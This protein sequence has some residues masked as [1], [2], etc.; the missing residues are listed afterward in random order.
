M[1]YSRRAEAKNRGGGGLIGVC[2]GFSGG[3]V[4]GDFQVG[5]VKGQGSGSSQ[6]RF[7]SLPLCIKR[8]S[9]SMPRRNTLTFPVSASANCCDAG[10]QATWAAPAG[11]LGRSCGHGRFRPG[12]VGQGQERRHRKHQPV[13]GDAGGVGPSGL[14]PLPAHALDGLEAQ[15]DPEAESVPTHSHCFRRQVGEDDPGFL[16]AGRTRPPAG[17]S[18]VGPWGC[19]RRCPVRSRPCRER[20]R[21]VARAI[22]C[23]R[24]RRR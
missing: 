20:K 16:L 5:L 8:R 1:T 22:V 24:R 18:G 13:A 21:S 15:F 2:K 23:R 14:V 6:T 10:E 12:A 17:C 19:R 9:Q 11:C 4:A 7:Q 3:R